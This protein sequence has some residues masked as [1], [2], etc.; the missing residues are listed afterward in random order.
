MRED[1]RRNSGFIKNLVAAA[2]I[3]GG[4]TLLFQ[5]TAQ[6]ALGMETNRSETVST[7]YPN[8]VVAMG[9][10]QDS[11]LPEG[12]VKP[13]YQLVDNQLEYYRDKKPSS[14][15][16]TRE[17]AAELGVQGLYRVF[18]LDMNG[19]VIEM[20]YD[21]AQD[22]HRSTWT[23]NWR[24]NGPKSSSEAYVEVYSFCVDAVSG[25]LHSVLHDRVL[26]GSVNT[27][28]DS[29]A[30]QNTGDYEALAK[31]AAVRLGAI[32]GTVNQV[33]YE[34]Q[35]VTCNDPDIFFNLTG[36]GGDRAQLRFSRYDKELLGITFDAGMKEMDVSERNA[37]DFAKRAEEYFKQ[38]P[39]AES[40]EE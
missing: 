2:C 32:K 11:A 19:K 34:G 23:G 33:E 8:D 28:F 5:G 1:K 3:I 27:G 29:G 35:G 18:G 38:N 12:Y 40:Y 31:E 25:E 7:S 4:G 6:A 37:E 30:A 15:E 16:L 36:Q 9:K 13:D 21:P 26:D 22:G 20:T 24:P 14:A 17:Q 10:M 39:G